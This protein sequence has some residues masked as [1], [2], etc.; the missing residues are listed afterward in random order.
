MHLNV[1]E[2]KLE[3]LHSKGISD[4]KICEISA[5]VR[6]TDGYFDYCRNPIRE[7]AAWITALE[8]CGFEFKKI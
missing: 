1:S 5:E 2:E 3:L 6:S 4:D 8:K 7:L